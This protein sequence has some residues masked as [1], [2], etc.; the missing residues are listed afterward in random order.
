VIGYRKEVE[1]EED[2]TEATR[3]ASSLI[4]R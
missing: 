4:L 3:V 1:N 2:R